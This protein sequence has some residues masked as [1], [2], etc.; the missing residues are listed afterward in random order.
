MSSSRQRGLMSD[1][2]STSQALQ[3]RPCTV[4]VPGKCGLTADSTCDPGTK[5]MQPLSTVAS[6][7]ANQQVTVDASCVNGG[8]QDAKRLLFARVRMQCCH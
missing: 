4:T 1:R 5:R 7:T 8:L 3:M 2:G 6:V